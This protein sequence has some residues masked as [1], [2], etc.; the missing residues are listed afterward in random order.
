MPPG[1]TIRKFIDALRSRE[2]HFTEVADAIFRNPG[3]LASAPAASAAW[4][5]F[6]NSGALGDLNTPLLAQKSPAVAAFLQT[7]GMSPAEVAHIDKWDNGLKERI[8]DRL[9]RAIR[10]N[11]PIK[12][13]WELYGDAQESA[14]I[15]DSTITFRSPQ[16]G[17]RIVS[18]AVSGDVEIEK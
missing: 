18:A 5:E 10:D 16:T 4:A 12:F 1:T 9:F 7:R 3:P 14:D 17:V 11:E 8:R 6:Q 2:T 15:G 13:Y